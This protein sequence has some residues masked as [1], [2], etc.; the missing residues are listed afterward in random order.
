MPK[1]FIIKSL[2]YNI[3]GYR[4]KFEKQEWLF[5]AAYYRQFSADIKM[6][7]F[8]IKTSFVS[9]ESR[10]SKTGIHIIIFISVFV[11]NLNIENKL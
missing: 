11:E 8:R 4:N 2:T 10:T 1:T 3:H 6:E 9:L 7:N 5:I